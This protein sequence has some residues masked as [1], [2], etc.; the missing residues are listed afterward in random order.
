[1]DTT[2][3]ITTA[4]QLLAAPDLGRCELVGGSLVMMSP[5][6]FEHGR[7]EIRLASRLSEFIERRG[8]GVVT[9]ADTG[10]VLARNP[11][12]VRVPDVGFVQK[13]RLPAGQITTFFPG[14][15]DLAVE[16]LSPDDRASEVL[17]KVEEYLAAGC[18]MVWL[19]DPA[20]R[21]VA[22]YDAEGRVVRSSGDAALAGE[23]LLPG[24]QLSL[25]DL[26]GA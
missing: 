5:A 20:T 24:F 11:D 6:G 1:M 15:P 19:V 18:Q 21:T 3:P 2:L 25:A 14:P 22:T 26:F 8:L 7:L 23:P 13:S 4:E 12:T 16:V 17:A 10:Y 9:G